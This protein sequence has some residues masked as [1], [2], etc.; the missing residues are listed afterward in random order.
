[1]LLIDTAK[2]FSFIAYIE[3]WHYVNELS[4][5]DI[6]LKLSKKNVI[7]TTWNCIVFFKLYDLS[8]KISQ[9]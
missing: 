3:L 1:M 9:L 4:S 2:S 7:S 8:S 6:W 5:S